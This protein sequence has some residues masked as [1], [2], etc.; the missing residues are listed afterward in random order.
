M[1]TKFT[2]CSNNVMIMVFPLDFD[3]IFYKEFD[4]DSTSTFRPNIRSQRYKLLCTL[5]GRTHGDMNS[6]TLSVIGLVGGVQ[7][8]L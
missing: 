8:I 6:S 7:P 5:G 3:L 2:Q 4:V 1:F